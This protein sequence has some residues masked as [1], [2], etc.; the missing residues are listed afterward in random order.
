MAEIACSDCLA[1]QGNAAGASDIS[2]VLV[3]PQE[4]FAKSLQRKRGGK[5][6]KR[7][8]GDWNGKTSNQFS[9]IVLTQSMH[10]TDTNTMNYFSFWK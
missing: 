6:K 2:F 9:T 5:E 8:A 4:R 3:G 1:V 7:D 10:T